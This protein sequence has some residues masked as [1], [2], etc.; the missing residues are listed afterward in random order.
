MSLPPPP[1]APQELR[2]LLHDKVDRLHDADLA[3]AH[4]LLQKLELQRL[5]DELGEDLAEGWASG[6]ITEESIEAAKLEH[7]RKHPYRG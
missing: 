2:P 4:E 1:A 6:R 3:A 5:V 7:R